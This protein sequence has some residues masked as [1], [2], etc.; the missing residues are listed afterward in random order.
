MKELFAVDMT[1][2]VISS[3]R[4]CRKSFTARVATRLKYYHPAMG[5]WPFVMQ[6]KHIKDSKKF[7][8]HFPEIASPPTLFT[9]LLAA[10]QYLRGFLVLIACGVGSY[11]VTATVRGEGVVLRDVVADHLPC[12]PRTVLFDVALN[13]DFK[14]EAVGLWYGL[15]YSEEVDVETALKNIFTDVEVATIVQIYGRRGPRRR[16]AHNRTRS[17][18]GV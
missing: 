11:Y 14:C 9:V 6:V 13:L 12:I 16:V 4:G 15:S 10:A 18:K 8:R 7:L 1:I 5:F 3:F 2:V 17:Q